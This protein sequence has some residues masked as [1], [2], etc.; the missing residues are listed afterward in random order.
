MYSDAL[1]NGRKIFAVAPMID[2][3]YNSKSAIKSIPIVGWLY[4]VALA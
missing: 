4:F 1:K 2:W 3:T